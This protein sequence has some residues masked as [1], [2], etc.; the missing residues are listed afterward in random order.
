MADHIARRRDATAVVCRA[1]TKHR[2]V[3]VLVPSTERRLSQT[4]LQPLSSAERDYFFLFGDGNLALLLRQEILHYPCRGSLGQF[5]AAAQT[6]LAL[7]V[8]AMSLDRFHAQVQG[9]CDLFC[10]KIGRAHV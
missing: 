9:V 2:V 10:T 5:G 7:N 6:K 8:F 3:A 1:R 4:P